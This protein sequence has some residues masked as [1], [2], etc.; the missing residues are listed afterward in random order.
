MIIS[1]YFI[2]NF[3][4]GDADFALVANNATFLVSTAGFFVL[5]GH[6]STRLLI[7]H[8]R[9]QARMRSLIDQLEDSSRRD[10]HTQLF[11]RRHL[12]EYLSTELSA[13][14]EQRPLTFAIADL[15]HFKCVNDKFGHQAG[16]HILTEVAHAIRAAVRR[17]DVVFRYGGEEFAIIFPCTDHGE[18]RW[19][20]ERLRAAVENLGL[21]WHGL[22]LNLSASIGVT[23]AVPGD[24]PEAVIRR[25]DQALYQAKNGGRNQIVIM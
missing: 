21:N 17:D 14:A 16:D 7:Q 24:S 22:T 20:A 19:V 15:D 5:G 25:A 9:D 8:Y 2:L 10:P 18:A 23:A 6:L 3:M 12:S 11:N 13:T 4:H 1:P